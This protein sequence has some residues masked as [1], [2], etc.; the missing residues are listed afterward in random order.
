MKKLV[1]AT[2]LGGAPITKQDLREVFNQDIWAAMEGVYTKIAGAEGIVVSGCVLSANGGNFDMTAGVVYV[3]GEFKR[4]AAVTNQTFSKWIASDA[5]TSDSRTFADATVHA[6]VQT[7]TAS[8]Q[9]SQPGS[10]QYIKIDS[11]TAL[12][13]KK[14]RLMWKRI[15]I[16]DWN[17]DANATPAAAINHGIGSYDLIEVVQAWIYTD[18]TTVPANSLVG[19]GSTGLAGGFIAYNSTTVNLS[20]V[21][22]GAFDDV[23]YDATG[24]NRGFVIIGYRPA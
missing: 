6:V 16:G 5:A 9:G 22:G 18:T 10:G 4:V 15:P 23:A 13:Y 12:D 3:D 1:T 7:K 2:D 24:F 11:L 21:T 20:R 17:M 19:V 8:I 14:D